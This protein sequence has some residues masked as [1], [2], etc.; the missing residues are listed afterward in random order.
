MVAL[1]ER[2]GLITNGE[3]TKAMTMIPGKIHKLLI[4]EV[5]ANSI[6]GLVDQDQWKQE[7]VECD[8]C[9]KKLAAGSL[10]KHLEVQH[11]IFRS[12][13][14]NRDLMTDREPETYVAWPPGVYSGVYRCPFPGCVGSATTKWGL[15]RHFAD[16]HPM[17]LVDVP[18]EGVLPKCQICNMQI[19]FRRAPNHERSQTCK[20]MGEKFNQHFN[21]EIAA[22]ALEETFTAYG[23]EL[24]QVEVFKYLGRYLA[25]ADNDAPTICKNLG[26]ARAMWG[27]LSRVLR[28]ENAPAKVCAS[29]YWAT[30]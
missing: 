14:L 18:G 6:E 7:K 21:A 9:R 30:V 13:V 26:K 16:R 10:E 27:R 4:E 15:R 20:R 8:H 29:F 28:K 22:R 19:N 2:V 12:L 25:Y 11:G 5:Y 3:K 24:E 17:D 1:F 23:V